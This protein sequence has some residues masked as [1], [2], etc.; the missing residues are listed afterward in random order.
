[1]SDNLLTCPICAFPFEDADLCATDITEGVCHAA[2]LDGSPTV[3]LETGEPTAGQI[4]TYRYDELTPTG[5]QP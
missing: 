4:A 5:E 1:M 3:D 2:C